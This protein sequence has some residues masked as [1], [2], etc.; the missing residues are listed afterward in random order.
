MRKICILGSSLLGLAATFAGLNTQ[1]HTTE[2][3]MAKMVDAVEQAAKSLDQVKTREFACRRPTPAKP[4]LQP[5]ARRTVAVQPRE[6]MPAQAFRFI[7]R[8]GRRK[9]KYGKN[10]WVILG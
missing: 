7:E 2:A 10:R 1:V 6:L 4:T 3:P 9:V 5:L 8:P